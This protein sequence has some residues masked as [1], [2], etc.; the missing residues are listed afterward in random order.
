M[1]GELTDYTH[2]LNGRFL[3][4]FSLPSP[5]PL[6]SAMSKLSPDEE[7]VILNQFRRILYSEGILRDDDTIGTDD[8]TLL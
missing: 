8:A 3:L 2:S 7:F 5:S 1:A 6:E 4:Y